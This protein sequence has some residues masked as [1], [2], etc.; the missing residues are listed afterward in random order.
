MPLEVRT[1]SCLC[2]RVRCESRG[3]P[4][5]SVVC[6]CL[7]CQ[8]GGRRI[9]ALPRAPRVLDDDGGAP[10]L[11]YRDDRFRCVAGEE[12]LLDHRLKPNSPTRRVVASCCNSGMFLKFDPGFWVSSYRH[13][14]SDEL[15]PIDMRT[16][17]RRRRADAPLPSDA[18]CYRSFPPKLFAKLIGARIAMLLGR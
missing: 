2:G 12:L 3:E 17:M 5:L 14:Y 11:L 13:R 16:N 15:P 6:Y 18:P 8:E 1:S 7:D 9:E 10:Y 4:I